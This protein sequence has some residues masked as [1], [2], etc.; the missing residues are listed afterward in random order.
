MKLS[1]I[2]PAYNEEKNIDKLYQKLKLSILNLKIDQ[3]EIIFVDDGSSDNT[4][5]IIKELSQKDPT[6][7]VIKLSRNFGQ[8]KAIMAGIENST[9]DTAVIMDSD[10][11]DDPELMHKMFSKSTEGFEIVYAVREKRKEMF[12]KRVLFFLFHFI[13][14]KISDTPIH[15]NSGTFSL[16]GKK[17][18]SEIKGMRE[19]RPYVPGLRAYAGFKSVGVKVERSA[20]YSGKGKSF[21]NLLNLARESVFAH[22]FFPLRFVLY[23][24]IFNFLAG[25]VLAFYF[26]YAKFYLSAD[27]VW[28]IIIAVL[29]FLGS[30]ILVSIYILG[31]Y[32][33]MIFDDVKKRPRYIIEEK[34]NF[35]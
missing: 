31:E 26:L 14:K 1:F 8:H 17:A 2:A 32:I 33:S 3:Y 9:G 11:Q 35:Q 22:S 23:A 25:I 24:A 18:L 6:V 15:E 21:K 19:Y 13:I 29:F 12:L 4:Y 10:L 5:K 16:I 27:I 20:R 7:K 30:T 34:I 28:M